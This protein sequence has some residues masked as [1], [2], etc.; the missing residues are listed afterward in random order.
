MRRSIIK[1][2]RKAREAGDQRYQCQR[3]L[4]RIRSG[5]AL[6]DGGRRR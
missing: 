4:S 6:S 1:G 2:E 3:N 5:E